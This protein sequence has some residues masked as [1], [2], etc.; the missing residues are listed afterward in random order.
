MYYF[1]QLHS[2]A[3]IEEAT[4]DEKVKPKTYINDI[5]NIYTC[6]LYRKG[7][8]LKEKYKELKKKYKKLNVEGL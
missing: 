1:M 4:Q 6:T 2:D 8:E 3:D 5:L 7:N